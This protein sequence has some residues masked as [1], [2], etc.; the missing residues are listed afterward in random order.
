MTKL[1]TLLAF[2][3][4][5]TNL[6]AEDPF[7]QGTSVV[8][9]TPMQ[10][11]SL[12]SYIEITRDRLERV[13]EDVRGV[14]LA[15]AERLYANAL[16]ATVLDSYRLEGRTELLTRYAINQGLEIAYGVPSADGKELAKYGILPAD[17]RYQGLRVLVLEDSVKLA[18]AVLPEDKKVLENGELIDLPFIPFA[19]K[20]L[21]VARMWSAAVFS[22]QTQ[23]LFMLR[24]LEHW[25]ST[26]AA[27]DQ[28]HQARL[29]SQILEVE[30]LLRQEN[31]TVSKDI[32]YI[33]SHLR[34]MRK[35]VR[36]VLD[37]EERSAKDI[38]YPQALKDFSKNIS[39][40]TT[41]QHQQ[42]EKPSVL[43]LSQEDSRRK[44]DKIWKMRRDV[45]ASVNSN[46]EIGGR[47]SLE[48]DHVLRD[49]NAPGN[50]VENMYKMDREIHIDLTARA[51]KKADELSFS[52]TQVRARVI[53]EAYDPDY[54]CKIEE[55]ADGICDENQDSGVSFVHGGVVFKRNAGTAPEWTENSVS[56]YTI[57]TRWTARTQQGY[58]AKGD[59]GFMQPGLNLTGNGESTGLQLRYFDAALEA[60]YQTKN[61]FKLS[62]RV[63]GSLGHG[64]YLDGQAHS[65]LTFFGEVE[66]ELKVQLPHVPVYASWNAELQTVKHEVPD[67]ASPAKPWRS[68]SQHL[69]NLGV[70]F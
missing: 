5:A 32:K 6:Y 14:P 59:F 31:K 45:S 64:D 37:L 54:T 58:Y 22:E 46:G 4:A 20:R 12:N 38:L 16:I 40:E 21:K 69:F 29:A 23:Y 35:L 25:L 33:S 28:L 11:E 57:G 47:A 43:D 61:G 53:N 1:I 68:N 8:R 70:D 26:V 39:G 56:A 67:G 3:F 13:V 51:Y 48:L 65:E 42:K 27:G 62:N 66:N 18:L 15:Q 50:P 10:R 2:V 7:A 63:N 17:D 30:Q 52:R 55:E 60:G 19:Y 34:D 44:K 24:V 36:R 49:T 9:L 41:L